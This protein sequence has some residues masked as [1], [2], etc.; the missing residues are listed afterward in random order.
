MFVEVADG[1]HVNLQAVVMVKA[2]GS[3]RTM[4]LI[5][6]MT[7]SLSESEYAIL[8]DAMDGYSASFEVLPMD[9][10]QDAA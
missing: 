9:D 5:D 7:Q 4:Y 6:G 1:I 2:L 8:K 3:H 10:E